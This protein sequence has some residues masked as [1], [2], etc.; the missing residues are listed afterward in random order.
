MARVFETFK[1]QTEIRTV[2]NF[3]YGVAFNVMQEWERAHRAET[4]AFSNLP[5]FRPEPDP[6]LHQC[7]HVC[8]NKLSQDKLELLMQASLYEKSRKE[9]AESLSIDEQALTSRIFRYRRTVANCLDDCLGAKPRN[10]LE[11]LALI[12]GRRRRRA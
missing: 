7:L 5:D 3:A 9:L 10:K 6:D 12:L 8:L 2:S 1:N 11:L 4:E